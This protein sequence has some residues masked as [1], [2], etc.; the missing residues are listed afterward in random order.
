MVTEH[1]R[2]CAFHDVN[3]VTAGDLSTTF[4]D[5]ASA[6]RHKEELIADGEYRESEIEIF[7]V[8]VNGWRLS[9]GAKV[10]T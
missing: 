9:P 6:Q 3:R 7:P 4:S 1:F 10:D 5:R 8:D 2:V